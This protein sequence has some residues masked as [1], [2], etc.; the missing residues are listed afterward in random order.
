VGA[1]GAGSAERSPTT[2]IGPSGIATIDQ[3]LVQV[4]Q[5]N[6]WIH[7]PCSNTPEATRD[8]HPQSGQVF[9][10]LMPASSAATTHDVE[11]AYRE[12]DERL[13]RAP[14]GSIDPGVTGDASWLG[15]AT[16][17]STDETPTVYPKLVDR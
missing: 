2:L 7:V 9:C 16:L 17:P 11:P 1:A 4:Q 13:R 14:P 8:P 5:V 3:Q 10:S 6:L 12:L 15:E